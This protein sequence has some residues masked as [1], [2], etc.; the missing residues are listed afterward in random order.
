M[1]LQK[2]TVA[3]PA[4]QGAPSTQEVALIADSNNEKR[5]V[6]IQQTAGVRKA[7]DIE[8]NIPLLAA[9]DFGTPSL[10][11]PPTGILYLFLDSSNANA[12]TTIDS[13]GTTTVVGVTTSSTFTNITV[14]A[15]GTFWSTIQMGKAGTAGA[16][17]LFWDDN[18]QCAMEYDPTTTTLTIG[19]KD[20]AAIDTIV[21]GKNLTLAG[22]NTDKIGF[23]GTTPASR[24]IVSLAA[25]VLLADCITQ[26]EELKA[27]L[28]QTAGVGLIQL[29]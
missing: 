17:R 7:I 14:T 6:K 13:T 25:P 8:L 2:V 29:S 20:G 5:L 1:S 11:F 12:L 18:G 21:K 15:T 28:G 27:A 23:F 9:A 24:G 10:P 26:I 22:L 4:E 19:T 16:R 3:D